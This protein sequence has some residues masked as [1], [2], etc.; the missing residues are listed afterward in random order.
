[1][2]GILFFIPVTIALLSLSCSAS[3][4]TYS[5][6]MFHGK[7]LLRDEDFAGARTDFLKAAE[8]QKWPSAYAF[9]ATASYKMGDLAGAERYIAEAERLDGR[10]YSY[11][12]VL[13]YKALTLLKQGKEEEGQEV[14]RRYAWILRSISSPMGA[15]QIEIWMRQQ[16]MDLPGLEKL[17]DQ[18][19]GQYES[20]IEQYQSTG[21]GFY[22]RRG[23][24][25]GG[26]S[27]A[28]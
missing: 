2:K 23:G 18:Q 21:T 17:I 12:R 13:G 9:A 7:R 8:A 24:F 11:L 10:D 19:V 1:M 26:P 6:D 14:L 28:P 5:D 15:R 16:H 20:D 27:I 25:G 3:W 4:N 22:Q